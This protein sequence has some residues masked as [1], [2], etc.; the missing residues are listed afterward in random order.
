[1]VTL[2]HTA[3][4]KHAFLGEIKQMSKSKKKAPR[5]KVSLELL[6]HRLGHI[7]TRSLMAGYTANIWNDI[8]LRIDT[9]P[10]CISCQ[11]SSMKKKARS[12]NTFNQGHL[13]NG[14]YGYYSRNNTNCFDKRD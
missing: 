1:M 2:P 13:S 4:R 7:S 8:E 11:I 10:F 12:K 14:S 6:H 3:Q 9:D 5:K